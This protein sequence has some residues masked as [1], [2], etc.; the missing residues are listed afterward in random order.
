METFDN[1]HCRECNSELHSDERGIYM[2]L[3]T[4]NATSFL[5]MDCLAK[6]LNCKRSDLQKRIDYYRES[7]NCVLF[8]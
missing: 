2:K 4:R 6:E 7:G 5:C 1:K 8:R 3:V